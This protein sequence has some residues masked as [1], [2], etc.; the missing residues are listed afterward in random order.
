MFS[1]P[2]VLLVS[3]LD[4]GAVLFGNAGSLLLLVHN[5]VANPV[6]AVLLEG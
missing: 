4:S 2:Y 5:V 3:L 1:I 6:H